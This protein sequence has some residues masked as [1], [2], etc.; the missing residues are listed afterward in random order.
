MMGHVGV[1]QNYVRPRYRSQAVHV[2]RSKA[3]LAGPRQ[4]THNLFPVQ[5]L[6]K[7]SSVKFDR[8][9]DSATWRT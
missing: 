4:N 6:N 3:H 7:R 1:H 5:T 2:G 9:L 8:L